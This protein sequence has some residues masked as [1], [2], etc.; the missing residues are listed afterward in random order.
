MN[1][2]IISLLI[3][4]AGCQNKNIKFLGGE[5]SKSLDEVSGAE[6]TVNSDYIWML[7]DGG[8]SPKLY[9]VSAKGNIK[10]EIKI[11]AKNHDWEDLTSDEEGNLYIGD[12]GNNDSKRKNL[13]IL[14]VKKTALN[15]KGKVDID[16]ISFSYPNQEKFPPKNKN[17]YFDCEAFFYHNNNFYLFTK[18]RV[19]N[20]FGKTS[21]Y[22]VPAKKGKHVAELLGTFNTCSDMDCWITSADISNNGKSI[23]LLSPKSVWVF[24]DFKGDD[25]FNGTSKEIPLDGRVSQKESIC[26]KDN[27]TLYITDEKAHGSDG[28]LYEFSLN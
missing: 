4:S 25:F 15:D 22:K 2:L 7:N 5:L 10:E 27:N 23:V 24:T 11:D 6:T 20:D 1:K 3:F 13:A 16:R 8:N 28:N 26:F 21:L 9:G 17:L 14:K 19:K 18:S 12:F